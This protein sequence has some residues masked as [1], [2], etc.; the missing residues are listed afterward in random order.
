MP[1][2]AVVTHGLLSSMFFYATGHHATIPSI[3]F[4]S[5]FTGFHGDFSNNFIPALL[6][7]LNTF[8]A[9]IF[10]AVVSPLLLLWPQ[11]QGPV[12]RWMVVGGCSKE[13]EEWKGDFALY[14]NGV[15]FR[16]NLFTSGCRMLLFH[17]VKVREK[18]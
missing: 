17:A 18:Y 11:L 1:W 2:I 15:L 7:T 4:E 8:A 6:I 16:K 10:F 9:P 3:R 13:R 14:D 12:S 5:A